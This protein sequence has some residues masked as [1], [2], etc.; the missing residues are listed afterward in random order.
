MTT[1]ANLLTQL[2]GWRRL[3]ALLAGMLLGL[4][5]CLSSAHAQSGAGSIQG[6][7]TDS[8]GA[9]I[10]GAAIHVVNQATNVVVDTKSNA[11]GFYQI[12]ELFSGTYVATITVPGMETY[13][14]TIDLLVAQTYE[15]DAKMTAGAVTQQVQVSANAVELV[16]TENGVI[17][18]TLENARIN[19]LPM[20]GRNMVSLVSETTPGMQSCPES[21]TCA[22]G[23]EAPSIEFEVD[24]AS[25]SNRQFG[26]VN[27][28]QSQMV[29]PDAVQE[30]TMVDNAA[31]VQYALPA[32]V[33]LSTK[34]GTNQLHGSL[35]E[36]ARNNDFGIARTRSESSTY[37]Q[38]EYIRN[39]FGLSAGGPIILPHVY[40]GKDKSFWFF[41]YERYSLAQVAEQDSYVPTVAE[42]NGDFSG[43]VNSSNVLQQLYDP[44][45]TAP[46]AVCPTPTGG[47]ANNPYCRT[48]FGGSSTLGTTTNYINPNHESPTAAV[49]N[50]ITPLPTNSNNPLVQYNLVANLPELSVEPQ[51]TFRLDHNFNDNNKVYLRYTQNQ[52]NSTS[53]R[54]NAPGPTTN[55]PYTLAAKTASG[56]TIPYGA[57]GITFTP[58]NTFATALGYT[59]VFSSTFYSE[60]VL[61]DTWMSQHN[62]AGGDSGLDYESILGLPNN[63]GE[64]GFPE[65]NQIVN[66]IDGTQWQYGISWSIPQIDENLTK[67]VGKHQ[68][69]FGGRYR[70]EQFITRPDQS[71]DDEQFSGQGTGLYN[72]ST[73]TSYG[74]YSNTGQLNADYYI[75]AAYD[76]SVNLEPPLQHIHDMEIDAYFQDN[77]RVRNNLTLNL[78]LRWEGHPATYM[79]QGL[80]TGFDFKNHA[81]VTTDPI[82]TLISKGFTT[83]AI[84]TNDENNGVVFE[85]PSEAGLP[86]MLTKNFYLNFEPRVGGA[87]KL[88]PKW[89]TVIR[90]AIGRYIYPEPI[91]EMDVKVDKQNPFQ[92]GYSV[93]Y[94][95]TQYAPLTNYM[96]LAPQNNSST[97]NYNTTNSATGSGTPVMGVN[98]AGV[99]NSSTTTAIAP[100]L[101]VTSLSPDYA[102]TYTDEADLTLEQPIK[103]NSAVRLSYVYTRGGNLNNY[104]YYNDHPSTYSWEIQQG[105]ETPNSSS[106]GPTNTTTG[107][108]PY[109]NT[110][111]SGNSFEIEKVGW[112]NY[113]A[114]QAVWQKLYSHGSAWQIMYTYS[115]LLRT[116]GDYGGVAGDY[117]NPYSAYVNTYE[118]NWVNAGANT[119]TVG[120]ADANSAMPAAPNL[121]PPPPAGVPAWGYYKALNRW[122]NYMVDTHDP[123]QHIQFNGIYDLPFGRGK[124]FLGGVNKLMD[125]LVGGWQ[126]AGAGSFTVTN[127]QITSTNW[128]PTNPLHIYKKS[129]PITDCRSGNC[130]KSYE[131]WNGYIAPTAISGNT[132]ATNT[133]TV[134]GL[135][136][137]WQA[138]QKPMDVVCGDVYYGDND[139]A[140]SGV[141]GLGKTGEA[142]QANGAVIGYGIVPGNNDN[143]SGGGAIDVT[144]PFGHTVLNG[145]MLWEADASLFK[146]FP[147][148]ERT[149]VRLNF[150]AFN[151]FNHQGIPNPSGSDGTV[152]VTPGGLG[153]SSANTGRQLQFTG[154]FTF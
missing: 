77:Y 150:D 17:T 23:G 29:D 52:T 110:L 154:R 117:I 18:V 12:P 95:S 108:G 21:S 83:Q 148:T 75:G 153:C 7:V 127:F 142:P 106:I 76:Y 39:E 137:N 98:S 105:S 15:A 56:V 147:I 123:P 37:A 132:C 143:G 74:G 139:V 129:A 97:F 40:H 55:A 66:G 45:S 2:Q 146:V 145:P 152:C 96:L 86:P 69:Q 144:N 24:G 118:G 30:T 79:A 116:G 100:G 42:R 141:T 128:G 13:K 19:Q 60:L 135:P 119:V 62:L 27:S 136:S 35:F 138:Y 82:S 51:I 93:N 58:F 140:M 99:V 130:L 34:S 47:T 91:R 70:Y 4:A 46:N 67:V 8:T 16:N 9:V 5:V 126:I 109:D 84:I 28:G 124:Q 90:G 71:S 113:N 31:S 26:G 101:S 80:M 115:K 50:A 41:A 1:L 85:T 38:P 25:L 81:M 89:G 92:T 104:L 65:I 48:A 78:G 44:N 134:N 121:P 88:S 49:L 68:F 3:P 111:Y 87:W 107:E 36:T 133:K 64:A 73:S 72:P 57:S 151:V 54:N 103:W 125:E 10:P 94:E 120:P 61:S 32:T 20:N 53:P 149:S 59:H 43:L 14:R 102:P 6:T 63:F 112:S 122:E 11:V 33:V 114:L 131:W 22:N